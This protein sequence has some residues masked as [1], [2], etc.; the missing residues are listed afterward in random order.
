MTLECC[1]LWPHEFQFCRQPISHM[2]CS[3]RECTVSESPLRPWKKEVAVAG[4][5]QQRA[6]WYVGNRR[7]SLVCV[8]L[9]CL[10]MLKSFFLIF[11]SQ[12]Q[13]FDFF[14][15]IVYQL[16]RETGSSTRW[17]FAGG[18]IC[19][20]ASWFS[21][22]A[23]AATV[24]HS[25]SSHCLAHTGFGGPNS[26]P[27]IVDQWLLRRCTGTHQLRRDK[28]VI[29][30]HPAA[31]MLRGGPTDKP[32]KRLP[33]SLTC[34]LKVTH[35]ELKSDTHWWNW[36]CFQQAYTKASNRAFTV[37]TCYTH[38]GTGCRPFAVSIKGIIVG[39]RGEGS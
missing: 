17:R 13:K 38:T 19:S 28:A 10:G 36:L 4:G 24:V 2:R 39:R 22:A 6:C 26:R 31:D 16:T 23:A 7:C 25:S 5:T 12:N 3:D 33:V 8:F 9:L 1:C 34:E 18:P 20:S 15:I 37:Q 27:G 35:R 14:S 32:G 21:L 30:R 29:K 11:D